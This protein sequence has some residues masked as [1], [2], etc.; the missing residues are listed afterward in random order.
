MGTAPSA[1]RVFKDPPVVNWKVASKPIPIDMNTVGVS[2]S[3]NTQVLTGNG[4]S[5]PS[6]HIRIQEIGSPRGSIDP[7]KVRSVHPFKTS[8]NRFSPKHGHPTTTVSKVIG[9]KTV[10]N[11]ST[12]VNSRCGMDFGHNSVVS[13]CQ[14]SLILGC[15]PP[16]HQINSIL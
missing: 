6:I 7:Q 15:F 14:T 8:I 9:R 1:A 10:A 11:E 2:P 13:K 16:T 4:T 12:D 3:A 5:T